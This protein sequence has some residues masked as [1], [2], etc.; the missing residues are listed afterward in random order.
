MLIFLQWVIKIKENP[1]LTEKINERVVL[2]GNQA[3]LRG[4]LEAKVQFISQYP[5]T[6]LSDIGDM[7]AEI[8][9]SNVLPGFYF[10]A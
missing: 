2:L 3:I 10:Q 8:M 7:S 5:G 6:P 1:I 9:Q 4:A